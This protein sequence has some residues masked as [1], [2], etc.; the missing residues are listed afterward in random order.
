MIILSIFTPQN[1]KIYNLND[2]E[3]HMSLKYLMKIVILN[4]YREYFF[5]KKMP[6]ASTVFSE[7]IFYLLN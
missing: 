7:N 2:S 3:S 5:E 1:N 6:K 4:I